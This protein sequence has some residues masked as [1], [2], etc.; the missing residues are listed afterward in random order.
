[1]SL[2]R[3]ERPF[4]GNLDIQ[5]D[6]GPDNPLVVRNSAG[7]VVWSISSAGAESTGG[8]DNVV[9]NFSVAT[10]KFTVAAATGNTVVGGTLGSTGLITASAGITLP[11][12]QTA[13]VTDA[14]KLLVGGVIVPQAN[15]LVEAPILL[16]ATKVIYNLFVARDAMQVT[17]IDYTPHIAQGGALTATVVKATGTATPASATTPMH[18]AGGI[19]LNAAAHTVQVKTLTVTTADLQLAAGDRIALVLSGAMTVGS[20]LVSI[21]GKRI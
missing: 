13:T 18:T 19:D 20:G 17:H 11:T 8:A 21:R 15:V 9:G 4:T 12:G 16:H 14:D 6:G 2:F 7:T 5:H 1:M 3:G 10:N